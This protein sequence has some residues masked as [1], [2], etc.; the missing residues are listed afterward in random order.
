MPVGI[1]AVLAFAVAELLILV[2]LLIRRG[3]LR[4]KHQRHTAQVKRLRPAAIALVEGEPVPPVGRTD[5]AVFA[6]LL[7]GYARALR[8]ESLTRIG[9]YFEA[10]GAVDDQ[11]RLLGGHPAWRRA[12][13]AFR[14]GD[15]RSTR[16]I[17]ALTDALDDRSRDVRMAAVRS[18]GSLGAIDAIEPLVAA[19]VSG[20]APRDVVGLALFDIGPPAVARLIELSSH[21]DPEMR[22]DAITLIGVLGTARNADAMLDHLVDPSADVRVSTASA[23]GRLGA[24]EASEALITALADRVPAVCA[25][26]AHALGQI[27]GRQAVEKL[28]PLAKSEAFE[29]AREAADA[30]ARIDP[31][32]VL[33]VASEPDAGPHLREAAD[34]VAL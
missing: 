22:A 17:P 32:L 2:V 7:S 26:A 12:T 6:E 1:I 15:M 10:S 3:R 18:L 13:A 28:L 19:G 29:P 27:G 11:M 24:A 30:M 31:V 33:R 25:A 4:R 14:L 5:E 9:M 8:G 20:R 23:L 34:V 16:A 21:P